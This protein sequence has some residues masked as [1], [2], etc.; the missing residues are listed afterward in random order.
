[1]SAAKTCVLLLDSLERVCHLTDTATKNR[2]ALAIAGMLCLIPDRSQAS[3]E[4]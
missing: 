1:M 4:P 3:L 2:F